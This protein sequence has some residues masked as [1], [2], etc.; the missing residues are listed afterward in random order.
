MEIKSVIE[1]YKVRAKSILIEIAIGDYLTLARE[2]FKQSLLQ[3]KRVKGSKSVYS[4]LKTDIM[5]GCVIPPLVLAYTKDGGDLE[6]GL[7]DSVVRDS[8]HF[9]LLDGLQRSHTLMD[10]ENE[11]KEQPELHSEFLD[12]RIRCEIYQGIDRLGILYRMLT[13]NTG[14]TAMSLRHQIEIMYLDLLDVNIAGVRLVREV[15]GQRARQINDYNFKDMIQGFNSYIERSETPIDRGEILENIKSLENLAKENKD[16][17]VFNSFVASW[18]RFILK[19][20]S[21]QLVSNDDGP[22]TEEDDDE[23]TTSKIWGRTGLQAFKRDQAVSGFGAAIGSL[24]DDNPDLEFSTL[25]IDQIVVGEDAEEFLDDL[26]LLISKI[27][28]KAKKIGNAQRLFFK[29]FFKMLFWEKSGCYLN[30]SKA[31]EAAFSSTITIGI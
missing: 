25:M 13:L 29:Q 7:R 21:F 11:L 23:S 19:V 8:K 28:S 16:T 22:D 2:M 31:K 5:M 14:Q 9:V 30:L 10:I 18:N 6:S 20:D 1:D 15:D 12:R 17:D 4:L 3:R 26:N 27:Q 24:R